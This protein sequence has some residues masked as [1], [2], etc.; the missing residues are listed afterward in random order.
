MITVGLLW[1]STSSDNLGVGALTLSQIAICK[2]AATTAGVAVRFVIFG[3]S[4]G[5]SYAPADTEIVQGS[6]ISLKQII[7]GRSP[8]IAELSACDLI[9]DIGEGDSFTDIYGIKRLLFLFASKFCV[10]GKGIPLVL[11]PQTIGP[12]NYWLTRKIAT[13]LMRRSAHVFARDCQSADYLREMGVQR[14]TSEG[15]DVSFRL[16]FNRP[17]KHRDGKCHIGINVSGLLFAGGYEGTNQFGLTLSYPDLL[18]KLLNKW[19]TDDGNAVWL[20]AHVIT[21]ALPREDDRVAIDILAQ[22]YPSVRMP[23]PFRSP[24]EAKSF[25]SGMNFVTGARLHACLAALSSGVAVMPVAYSR[26]FN[27]AFT[28]LRY[29]FFVD[30]KRESLQQAFSSICNALDRRDELSVLARKS[31]MQALLA[32]QKYEDYLRDLFCELASR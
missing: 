26:K 2:A 22:E 17:A 4:G 21:D 10:L 28:S 29:P 9:L 12:F 13:A 23:P 16:P 31:Q 32:L 25:I 3:T 14:N 1:H 27:G 5:Q 8:F 18:R 15:V 19:T 20:I 6:P 24:E 7:I 30:A 11:S